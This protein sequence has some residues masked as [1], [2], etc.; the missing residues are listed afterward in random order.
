MERKKSIRGTAMSASTRHA[1]QG[2]IAEVF[3][4]MSRPQVKRALWMAT[5]LPV[6]LRAHG[7]ARGWRR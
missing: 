2:I 1:D 4:A 6:R 3:P 7:E 5:R